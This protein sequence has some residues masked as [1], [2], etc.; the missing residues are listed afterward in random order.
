MILRS[1]ESLVPSHCHEV[2]TFSDKFPERELCHTME[3][4]KSCSRAKS[5]KAMA[6]FSE[7][8]TSP[9]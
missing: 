6:S 5:R 3:K 8:G 7:K 4:I 9:L 1:G 2:N